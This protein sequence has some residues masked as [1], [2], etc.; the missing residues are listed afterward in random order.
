MES[1]DDINDLDTDQQA[2]DVT[3]AMETELVVKAVRGDVPRS[4]LGQ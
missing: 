1:D 3:V 2:Y 4:K